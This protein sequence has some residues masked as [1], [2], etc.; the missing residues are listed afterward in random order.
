MR[1]IL[2]WERQSRFFLGSLTLEEWDAAG[3]L[4]LKKRRVRR[5]LPPASETVAEGSRVVVG[6]KPNEWL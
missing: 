5:G 1:R 6:W 3:F 4:K 2:R